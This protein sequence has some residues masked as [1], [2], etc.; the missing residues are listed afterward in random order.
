M[1]ATLKAIQA[2]VVEAL[3]H[4]LQKKSLRIWP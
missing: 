2:L 4:G 1:H 3:A